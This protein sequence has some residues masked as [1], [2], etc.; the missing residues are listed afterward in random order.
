MENEV[1]GTIGNVTLHT[2]EFF[3]ERLIQVPEFAEAQRKMI[4]GRWAW[5]DRE[6]GDGRDYLAGD[7]FSMAD[8]SGM[9]TLW[10][11]EVFSYEVPTN[12][13]HVQAWNAR[14]R[15]R[16]SWNA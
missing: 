14:L 8:I 10:L 7:E 9:V 13:P 5:L 1:F 15:Q 3:K 2:N 16:P 12:L 6:M 11:S 4:P